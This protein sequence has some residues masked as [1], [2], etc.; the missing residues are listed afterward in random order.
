MSAQSSKTG[1]F[2]FNERIDANSFCDLNY[3]LNF[4]KPWCCNLKMG[5]S[6]NWW[7]LFLSALSLSNLTNEKEISM[8]Y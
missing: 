4:S 5:V 3:L 2:S 1:H 8:I 7:I 6:C